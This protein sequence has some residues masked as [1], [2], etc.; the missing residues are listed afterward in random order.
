MSSLLLHLNT[1]TFPEPNRFRPERWIGNPHLSRSL[2]SFSKGSK[3]C[4]GINLAYAELYLSVYKVWMKFPD[5]KVVD[6]TNNDVEVV[7]DYFIPVA[8]GRGVKVMM[9]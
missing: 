7:A 4:L 2:V 1:K 6:T 8:S 5:M 9:E 3:Q